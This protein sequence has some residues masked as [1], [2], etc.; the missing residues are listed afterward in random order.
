MAEHSAD[1]S[2]RAAHIRLHGGHALVVLDVIAAGVKGDALAHQCHRAVVLRVALI[3]QH[4]QTG[5]IDTAPGHCQEAAHTHLLDLEFIENLILDAAQFCLGRSLLRQHHRGS[6]SE[7][8]VFT[9]SRARLVHS[10]SILPF[11]TA[12]E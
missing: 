5:R 8:G 1:H 3:A 2:R 10:P 11:C 7:P 4:D 6:W 12:A 9:R